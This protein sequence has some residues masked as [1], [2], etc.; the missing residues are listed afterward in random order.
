[1]KKFKSICNFLAFP[2]E[3]L[4]WPHSHAWIFSVLS[5]LQMEYRSIDLHNQFF[6]IL[7]CH[8]TASHKP[9]KWWS[10]WAILLKYWLIFLSLAMMNY[11]IFSFDE[12]LKKSIFLQ[13]QGAVAWNCHTLEILSSQHASKMS[14]N[15]KNSYYNNRKNWKHAKMGF[16]KLSKVS[17]F[18]RFLSLTYNRNACF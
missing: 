18:R 9:S 4:K 11:A 16:K 10:K 6:H 15:W 13:I 12:M 2:V 1:M 5:S 7:L 3:F 8:H 14:E 17:F